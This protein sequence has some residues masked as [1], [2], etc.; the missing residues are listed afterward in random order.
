MKPWERKQCDSNILAICRES[1]RGSGRWLADLNLVPSTL[2]TVICIICAIGLFSE[3]RRESGH[4]QNGVAS[5]RNAESRSKAMSYH[6]FDIFWCCSFGPFGSLEILGGSLELFMAFLH[7]NRIS[8]TKS[9]RTFLYDWQTP[10]HFSWHVHACSLRST[11]L[12]WDFPRKSYMYRQEDRSL[13]I[14][15]RWQ[16]FRTQASLRNGVVFLCSRSADLK[17]TKVLM[18]ET[19]GLP[20]RLGTCR[21]CR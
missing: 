18:L 10:G 2:H 19:R 17:N 15:W 8:S 16:T 21:R 14:K 20:K 4:S 3:S 5:E 11:C 12:P 9:A 13:I 6:I 1:C 7:F